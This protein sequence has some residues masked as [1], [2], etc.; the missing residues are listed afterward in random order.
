M[1]VQLV[2]GNLFHAEV[3]A[4]IN[5]VNTM[6]V[7]GK[8]IALQF[9]QA[10]PEN[11]AAYQA[12]CRQ[13]KVQTGE[14][15]VFET[16]A[17]TLPRYV[18]NFPTKR[19]WRSPSRIED[20]E[21]GLVHLITVVQELE[22]ASVAI[23]PLG[24]GNGGL[25]WNVV[26]PLIEATFTSV[27]NV[28]VQLFTPDG[29][30]Q[31]DAMPVTT[32]RPAM[33]ATRAALLGLL[34][35]YALPGYRTTLLEIQK[36]VYLLQEAGEPLNL[37]YE[38]GQFG[39]YAETLHYVMQRMEGHFLR[40]YGDRSRSAE[41]RV[42]PDAEREA[43]LFLEEHPQT[44]ERMG[45]VTELIDGFETPRGLELLATVHWVAQETPIVT[46]FTAEEAVRRVQAWSPRKRATF[47]PE[48]IEVA[49][50]RLKS[51]GW[52]Q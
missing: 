4:V 25:D 33:T 37:A 27:P 8:G 5:T 39:P 26:R 30:P 52:L 31:A 32:T 19:N 18:I 22:I 23:P 34:D 10:F 2:S 11:F 40:G 43:D 12:A 24:C 16:G 38:K 35:R 13:G 20:V 1:S 14:M 51:A 44:L 17:I 42:L 21:R 48:H 29:A 46:P 45:M 49:W 6:G 28:H 7:M 15:F 47:P 50:E 3:D 41:V 36:L 9:K